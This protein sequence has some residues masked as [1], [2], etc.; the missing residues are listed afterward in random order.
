M[1][2]LKTPLLALALMMTAVSPGKS[3]IADFP[4]DLYDD[5]LSRLGQAVNFCFHENPMLDDF[6]REVAEAIAGSLLIDANI[7]PIAT[8]FPADPLDYRIP[9]TEEELFLMMTGRCN[10]FLGFTLTTDYP[11]WLLVTQPYFSSPNVLIV[12]D[13]QYHGLEDIS[14]ERPLGTRM[15]S[16]EDNRLGAWISVLPENQRWQRYPYRNYGTA[17]ERVMDG[18]V[19]GSIVWE[20]AVYSGTGGDPEQSG[21]NV[22]RELPFATTPVELGIGIRAHERFLEM[23]FSQAIELLTADGTLQE[24][25]AQF[26]LAPAR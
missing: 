17:F 18:T 19:G 25:A 22:I 11:D 3:Q 1:A 10:A 15:F 12:T 26:N 7:I 21:I 5:R 14:A 13:P 20:A 9:F 8:L 24:L 23:M 16:S 4:R 2:H 6:H